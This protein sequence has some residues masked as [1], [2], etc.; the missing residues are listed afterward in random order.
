MILLCQEKKLSF[1]TKDYIT[2]A[3]VMN[4][5]NM[6]VATLPKEIKQNA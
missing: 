2:I 6:F 4:I 1:I 5:D 3:M